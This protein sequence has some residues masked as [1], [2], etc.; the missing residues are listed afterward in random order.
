MFNKIK[1]FGYAIIALLLLAIG[2][3]FIAFNQ[4]LKWLTVSIGII[5]AVF[6]TVF[7]IVTIAKRDRGFPFVMKIVLAVIALACGVVTAILNEKAAEI[8]A[9]LFSLLLIVDGSF[10]LNTSAMSKRYDVRLWWL[11]LIPA[12][13]LIVGGFCLIKFVP[14][15]AGA[16]SVMLGILLI[17]D[18]I[19]N[20]ASLFYVPSYERSMKNEVLAEAAIEGEDI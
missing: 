14:E 2:I 12:V 13:L 16:M 7:G 18:A 1:Y 11:M 4:S 6:G 8:V 10:K 5:L 19:I 17:I 20:F 15:T 9:A 3:L